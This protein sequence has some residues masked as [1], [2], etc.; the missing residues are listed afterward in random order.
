MITPDKTFTQMTSVIRVTTI[1][2]C[3]YTVTF[4]PMGNT[5]QFLH[6]AEAINGIV[7]QWG[8]AELNIATMTDDAIAKIAELY[9]QPE[10]VENPDE[11][12]LPDK[13]VVW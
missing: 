8:S 1:G 9:P 12:I 13:P 3:N 10:S 4:I 6:T 2:T 11:E 5:T 7:L